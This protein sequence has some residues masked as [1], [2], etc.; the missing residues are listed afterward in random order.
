MLVIA[1]TNQN[2]IKEIAA[3]LGERRWRPMDENWQ[4]QEGTESLMANAVLKARSGGALVKNNEA[5]LAEDTGL[6]VPA[7]GGAPGV[8]SSRYAG[9]NVPFSANVLKLLKDMKNFQGEDRRAYF[10]TVAALMLP[11]GRL[12]LACGRL[13]G[14]ILREPSPGRDFGYDP[15]FFAPE[16]GKSLAQTDLEEKNAVSHRSRAIKILLPYITNLNNEK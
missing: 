5:V 13:E 10:L 7:L 14:A 1:T 11:N 12:L 16:L 8:I 4:V 3:L 9:E 2:K 15:I 6:F